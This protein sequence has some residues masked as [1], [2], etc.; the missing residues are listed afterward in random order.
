[1]LAGPVLE[2][3]IILIFQFKFFSSSTNCS[4]SASKTENSRAA[5]T[6]NAQGVVCQGPQMYRSVLETAP[7]QPVVSTQADPTAPATSPLRKVNVLS[8]LIM[9][10]EHAGCSAPFQ[11]SAV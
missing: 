2:N 3:H 6:K 7:R 10:G 9:R 8:I 4:S 11:E 1:M 5:E